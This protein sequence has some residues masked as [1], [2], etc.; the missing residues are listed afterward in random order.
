MIHW[1]A[2]ERRKSHGAIFAFD[3]EVVLE[4][5]RQTVKW[6]YD[7]T[8]S[9]EVFVEGFGLCNCFIEEGIA[10]T[11]GLIPVRILSQV[12]P[13]FCHTSWWAA[14]A[15][16]QKAAVTSSELHVFDAIF[17]R[18]WDAVLSVISSSFVVNHPDSLGH[19]VTLSWVSGGSL[20]WGIRYDVGIDSERAARFSAATFSHFASDAMAQD[21][22]N[23]KKTQCQNPAM[24]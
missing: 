3:V 8:G 5:D 7:L 18:I 21:L 16:L 6:S 17:A 22:C 20:S 2:D 11:V 9:L 23:T 12:S 13:S 4:R 14:D 19:G 24:E 10:E 1:L 15:R